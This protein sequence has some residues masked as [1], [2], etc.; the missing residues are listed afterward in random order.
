MK[1]KLT[2]SDFLQQVLD[3]AKLYGW[4]RFHVRPGM[5]RSGKWCTAVQGDGVGF[6]D[7]LLVKGRWMIAAE[8]KVGHRQAE[9]EQVAWLRAFAEAGVETA[10]WRPMDWD[11]IQE[12]LSR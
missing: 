11:S 2:E 9:P 12:R 3:L 7:L 4:R 5:M 6:P 10:I 8:L 1:S